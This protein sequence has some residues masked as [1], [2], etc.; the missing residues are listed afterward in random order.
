MP[1]SSFPWTVVVTIALSRAVP[2]SFVGW[3]RLPVHGWQR[4]AARGPAPASVWLHAQK[5]QSQSQSP[6]PP[7]APPE[8]CDVDGLRKEAQR[9]LY[10]AQKRRPKEDRAVACEAK[11]EA[12]LEE[13]NASP[14]TEALAPCE[15]RAAREAVA[16]R[17]SSRASSQGSRRQ[18]GGDP[19][20]D[21]AAGGATLAELSSWRSV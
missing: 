13:E 15:R 20:E 4:Y 12:L 18:P 17:E 1:R 8:A 9:K 19:A 5:Q 2:A 14:R 7:Q 16:W 21:A 3:L 10:R 11:Q 6:P